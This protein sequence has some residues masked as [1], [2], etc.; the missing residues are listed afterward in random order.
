MK[1]LVLM[2]MLIMLTGCY[3]NQNPSRY[4]GC[5]VT[6]K[7][8]FGGYQIQVKLTPAYTMYKEKEHDYLWFYTVKWE[9]DKL[10]IGDTIK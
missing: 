7:Q 8:Y 1:K 9:A 6:D 4:R 2:L 5:V 3:H 10:N